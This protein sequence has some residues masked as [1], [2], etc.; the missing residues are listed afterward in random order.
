MSLGREFSSVDVGG[1]HVNS[2]GN[3][4]GDVNLGEDLGIVE[5]KLF[6]EV[7]V[8]SLAYSGELARDVLLEPGQSFELL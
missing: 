1:S 5:G 4:G 3:A 7:V 6:A 2:V 8:L